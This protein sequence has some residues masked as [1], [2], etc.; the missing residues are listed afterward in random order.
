MMYDWYC[1]QN[2]QS[3]GPFSEDI[4]REMVRNRELTPEALVWSSEA[5]KDGRGWLPAAETEI[6][7]L[8]AEAESASLFGETDDF[9]RPK[10]AYAPQP[11]IASQ[12]P[13]PVPALAKRSSRF[14]AYLLDGLLKTVASGIIALRYLYTGFST[15]FTGLGVFSLLLLTCI[16]VYYLYESGQSIGKKVI[17]IMIA[18]PDG[19]KAPLWRII[20]LRS[21]LFWVLSVIPG[22]NAIVG[23]ADICFLFFRDDRRMLHDVVAGTTVLE[24]S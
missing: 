6:A 13:A 15:L 3:V 8:F 14:W 4:L 21:A 16:N 17:G 10:R 20:F 2:G 18:G 12:Q 22:V 24:V 7:A 1:V 11:S 23:L 19:E 9:S 5:D